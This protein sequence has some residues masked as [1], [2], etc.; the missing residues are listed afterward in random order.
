M[1][2]QLLRGAVIG[3]G[4]FAAY[5]A[6]AWQRIPAVE[7]VAAAD[8]A[9]GRGRVF[10]EHW[11]IPRGYSDAEEMLKRERPD[12]VD[13]VT[14]PA[15]HLALVTLA[16]DYG[17]QVI[18]QKPMAPTW[19]ECEGMIAAARARDVRLLVHENWRWQPWFREI[20]RLLDDGFCGEVFHAGFRMRA[21]DGRGAEPYVQ[22]PYFR[23]MKRLLIDEM[24]V[25]FLDTFR[26]LVGE[27][28]TVYCQ[29]QRIN[30]AIVGE[31][32]ALIELS[33][34][35]GA[36]GLID[37]NRFT[38]PAKPALTHATFEI[39]GERGTIR[40]T[41]EGDI[42]LNDYRESERLHSFTRP[43]TGYKGDSV[44]AAQE[45]YISCL[46]QGVAC[47]TEGD[48]YLKTVASVLACYR[49]AETGQVVEV[50][51]RDF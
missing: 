44:H 39:E 9:T 49:S 11:G 46:R 45:H 33:F 10:A 18:C 20:K 25:H 27:I 42:W 8:A 29:L 5:H 24:L 50:S 31:D 7:I 16:A 41:P 23:D 40:L 34:A 38:G 1:K 22:Q 43:E 12:F 36:Q 17:A 15:T 30:P 2:P 26:F 35:T 48:E 32:C 6:E 47:E 13:I 4:Y 37:A 14:P 51:A 3:A 19:A 21:G 28:A